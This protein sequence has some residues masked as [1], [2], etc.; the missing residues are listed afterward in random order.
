MS[1]TDF[2]LW[3]L[4]EILGRLATGW[5]GLPTLV[6]GRPDYRGRVGSCGHLGVYAVE[7]QMA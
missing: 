2:G 5:D 4:P 1:R 3:V 7:G 6:P